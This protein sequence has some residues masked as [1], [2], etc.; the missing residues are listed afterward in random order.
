[1]AAAEQPS[2]T[3]AA[4]CVPGGKC[5]PCESLDKSHLLSPEQIESELTNMKLWQLSDDKTKLI[6]NYTARNFQ[7]A[8][9][10]LNAIGVIAEREN[11]HP[12]MHLTSYRTVEIVLFTHSLGGISLNDIALA[13]MIDEE[14]SINYSPKWLKENPEARKE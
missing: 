11:H 1:M 3:A 6:R 14:V 9:D 10:S 12:D 5:L 4:A 13:K 7:A 8:M 2:S